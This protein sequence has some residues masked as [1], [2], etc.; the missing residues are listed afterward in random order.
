MDGVLLVQ[1]RKCGS[2]LK[3]VIGKTLAQIVQNQDV[4]RAQA[5]GEKESMAAQWRRRKAAL[6]MLIAVLDGG[7]GD[8]RADALNLDRCA[9]RTTQCPPKPSRGNKCSTRVLHVIHRNENI[10]KEKKNVALRFGTSSRCALY[11]ITA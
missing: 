5:G 1:G 10:N 2:G 9:R 3:A 8:L 4:A 11:T 7:I 6:E